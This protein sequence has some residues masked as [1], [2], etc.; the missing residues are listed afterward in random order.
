M[1]SMPGGITGLFNI[2]E[3][4]NESLKYNIKKKNKDI[5][6]Y[7]LLDYSLFDKYLSKE[8]YD[9]LPCKY[10]AISIGKDFI[11]WNTIQSYIDRWAGRLS[12]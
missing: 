3:Y 2:F 11:S 8:L 12:H 5:K 6:K 9:K 1:L 7:G 10:M 4:E